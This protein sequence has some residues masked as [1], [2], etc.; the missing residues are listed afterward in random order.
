MNKPLYLTIH[1]AV[2]RHLGNPDTSFCIF[3]PEE[4]MSPKGIE[5]RKEYTKQL[6]AQTGIEHF[7]SKVTNRFYFI[8]KLINVEHDHTFSAA[9]YNTL[10]SGKGGPYEWQV[11]TIQVYPGN[12]TFDLMSGS[13]RP[14]CMR[15]NGVKNAKIYPDNIKEWPDDDT[16]CD[17]GSDFDG[18]VLSELRC[19]EPV[20]PLEIKKVIFSNPCTIVFWGDN[21]KTVVRCGENDLYDP[22]KGIAMAL[23]RK[24]YGPRHAY[25]KV[26]GPYIEEFW[27]KEEVKEQLVGAV[28]SNRLNFADIL[29]GA[30]GLFTG[31]KIID[32]A[33]EKLNEEEKSDEV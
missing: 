14:F 2:I 13:G 21:T 32:K 16:M 10:I 18:D 20:H 23:M 7:C 6:T 27:R 25:M 3:L 29:K 24:V 26:L 17:K 28:G 15:R 11:S 1:N 33:T 8:A 19:P 22:E 31:K 4:P 12:G 9:W 30:T 5:A